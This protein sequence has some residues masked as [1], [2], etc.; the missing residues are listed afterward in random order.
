M[1]GAGRRTLNWALCLFEP[2]QRWLGGALAVPTPGRVG[3]YFLLVICI[4]SQSLE[5]LTEFSLWKWTCSYNGGSWYPAFLN[6]K[7]EPSELWILKRRDRDAKSWSAFPVRHGQ[8]HWLCPPS[9]T[10]ELPSCRSL[11]PASAPSSW[12]PPVRS[13]KCSHPHSPLQPQ[14]PPFTR[15]S[16]WHSGWWAFL[17]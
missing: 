8:D 3:V 7:N 14:H 16:I 10:P 1:S 9:W 11:R 5:I 12:I 6:P 17:L 13:Q 15:S 2:K 4:F